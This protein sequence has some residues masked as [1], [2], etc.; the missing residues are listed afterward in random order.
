MSLL[1][2]YIQSYVLLLSYMCYS[3]PVGI[4]WSYCI[5]TLSYH[6]AGVRASTNV[7]NIYAACWNP[8]ESST[9]THHCCAKREYGRPCLTS[10]VRPTFQHLLRSLAYMFRS[11]TCRVSKHKHIEARSRFIEVLAAFKQVVLTVHSLL[12]V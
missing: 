1:Q 9:P 10:P 11:H 5:C 2:T 6:S 4:L 12:F 7:A 8:G 3:P